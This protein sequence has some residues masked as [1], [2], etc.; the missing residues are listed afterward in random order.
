MPTARLP[1]GNRIQ[2]IRAEEETTVN[3][4]E[5][6]DDLLANAIIKTMV[7]VCVRNTKLEDLHAGSCP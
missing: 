7:L 6:P 1:T 3:A 2:G 5:H 4:N